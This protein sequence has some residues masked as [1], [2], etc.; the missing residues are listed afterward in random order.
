MA[1][2]V[3]YGIN[4]YTQLTPSMANAAG[5]S[6]SASGVSSPTV[7]SRTDSVADHASARIFLDARDT[8]EYGVLRT[9]ARIQ[10]DR[11][12]GSDDNSGS[13]PRRG[14]YFSGSGGQYSNLQT[15]FS[16]S[17]A[18]VQLGGA[19]IGRTTS[20]AAV[21]SPSLQFTTQNPSA[22]R[23]NQA[24]FT[25][26]LGS[27]MSLTAAIEDGAELREGT[28]GATYTSASQVISVAATTSSSITNKFKMGTTALGG[29]GVATAY[30]AGSTVAVGDIVLNTNPTVNQYPIPNS[31][32]DAVASF[33]VAQS[34]GTMKLA[35]VLHYNQGI[36]TTTIDGKTGYAVMSSAK[37]NM[38]MIAA[39]DYISVFGAYGLGAAGR[40]IGGAATDTSGLQN[41]AMGM[42]NAVWSLYD[43]VVVN[44]ELNLS[45]SY[46][47]GG[48]FKHYFAPSVAAYVGGTFGAINY[49]AGKNYA[50][51]SAMDPHNANMWGT[52]IGL[53][54][55]P[56]AGFEVNPE[57]AYRKANISSATGVNNGNKTGVK[58][59]DQYI[60]RLRVARSF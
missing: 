1:E 51:T 32:P 49:G 19:L 27:G 20:F 29:A 17:E 57:V 60:G 59:D 28:N 7:R 50:S 22:G 40:T 26:A 21:S 13:Q 43:S 41:A 45:K 48:E 31:T 33:D 52:A 3:G 36:P 15:G 4:K 23:V 55:T 56:V 46:S 34:W 35:G 39:G 14:Q 2:F 16:G 37:I 53:I 6:A 9:F 18:F 54:W 44:G 11:S 8:T 12:S 47:F 38:P 42:G 25:A 10:W 5:T 30:A 24:A 58:S